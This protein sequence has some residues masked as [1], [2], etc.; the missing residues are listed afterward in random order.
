MTGE[1]DGSDVDDE[2][3][4]EFGLK[5]LLEDES[6]SRSGVGQSCGF[7]KLN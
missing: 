4:D 2:I 5:N 1:G 6:N 3:E 7:W